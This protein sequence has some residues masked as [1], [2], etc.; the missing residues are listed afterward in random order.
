MSI[1]LICFVTYLIYD[2]VRDRR[3]EKK[4]KEIKTQVGFK[5]DY[6][7]PIKIYYDYSD[8]VDIERR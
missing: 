4:L 8:E 7:K 3:I 2:Y 1:I 6:E 5:N